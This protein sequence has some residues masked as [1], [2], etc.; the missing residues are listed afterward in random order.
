MKEVHERFG[1]PAEIDVLPALI[2]KLR[3]GYRKNSLQE[4]VKDALLGNRDLYDFYAK[5]P[6]LVLDDIDKVS[7]SAGGQPSSWTRE[8]VFLLVN[9]RYENMLPTIFTMNAPPE[10]IKPLFGEAVYS[11]IAEMCYFIRDEG[12]DYRMAFRSPKF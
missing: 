12:A 8:V 10:A 2:A 1:V 11:R 3:Q 9:Y 6:L 5:V 7:R 4:R